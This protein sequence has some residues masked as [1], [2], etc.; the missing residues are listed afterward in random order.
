MPLVSVRPAL[1]LLPSLIDP[2]LRLLLRN[3]EPSSD[4]RVE[5]LHSGDLLIPFWAK[6][7]KVRFSTIKPSRDVSDGTS[8][9]Q[10]V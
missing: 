2:L 10:S 8:L 6:E 9:A 5:P 3:A 1:L 7:A 4:Y